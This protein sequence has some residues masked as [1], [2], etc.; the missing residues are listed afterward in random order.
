MKNH[1]WYNTSLQPD[2]YNKLI[3]MTDMGYIFQ[4]EYINGEWYIYVE[5]G[6]IHKMYLEKYKN[7]ESIIKWMK[8]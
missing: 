8:V 7:Q 1:K 6:I 4:G 3:I 5:N 2:K